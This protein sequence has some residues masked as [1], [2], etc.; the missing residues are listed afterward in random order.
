ML[1]FMPKFSCLTKNIAKQMQRILYIIGSNHWIC[2][3]KKIVNKN[4]ELLLHCVEGLGVC[5]Q[6]YFKI[7]W[8]VNILKYYFNKYFIKIIFYY[9]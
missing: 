7:F 6:L 1:P 5:I 9:F 2:I 4:I 3:L 8:L